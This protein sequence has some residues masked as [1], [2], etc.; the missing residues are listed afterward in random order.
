M[1]EILNLILSKISLRAR[2]GVRLAVIKNTKNISAD[3]DVEE[4]LFYTAS[5]DEN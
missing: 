1:C 3:E 5:G 2:D 4:K